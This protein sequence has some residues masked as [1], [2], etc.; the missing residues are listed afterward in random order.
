MTIDNPALGQSVP[1][2]PEPDG[3]YLMDG[4]AGR[5]GQPPQSGGIIDTD[6]PQGTTPPEWGILWI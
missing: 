5:V 6:T 2:Q 4:I 1:K 3:L